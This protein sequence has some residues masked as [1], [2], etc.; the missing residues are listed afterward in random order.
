MMLSHFPSSSGP[1]Q[2]ELVL[3][4]SLN[5]VWTLFELL[6]M[7]ALLSEHCL[8]TCAIWHVFKQCSNI[9]VGNTTCLACCSVS[10]CIVV[11]QGS[12]A[13]LHI[14]YFCL[15]QVAFLVKILNSFG[16]HSSTTRWHIL[17]G[18][19]VAHSWCGGGRMWVGTWLS[20]K[21]I[22]W[23]PRQCPGLVSWSRDS[24]PT[25]RR[26][27]CHRGLQRT[28]CCELTSWTKSNKTYLLP[29]VF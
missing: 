2:E 3:T 27:A 20:R 13:S 28:Y 25:T 4:N 26:C 18:R 24:S 29:L 6:N 15:E 5:S 21:G 11:S 1:D 12:T 22:L 23:I 17:H 14:L 9:S 16:N 7:H 10:Y 19:C 8:N